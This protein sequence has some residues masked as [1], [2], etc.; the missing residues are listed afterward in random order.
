MR[1]SSIRFQQILVTLPSADPD[2]QLAIRKRNPKGNLNFTHTRARTSTGI[3]CCSK[4]HS[5]TCY[6]QKALS[7]GFQQFTPKQTTSGSSTMIQYKS[8]SPAGRSRSSRREHG[9]AP[10]ELAGRAEQRGSIASLGSP[11]QQV[12]HLGRLAVVLAPCAPPRLL[13]LLPQLP[14]RRHPGVAR[15]QRAPERR[16]LRPP[17]LPVA[18]AA[19]HGSC[20]RRCCATV[21]ASK[22]LSALLLLSP[23]TNIKS[24]R[25]YL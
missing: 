18:A 14:P 12:H 2:F 7:Y 8:G 1:F 9:G 19:A 6:L 16:E 17:A 20:R 22:H 21:V 10:R 24:R 13:L 5:G 3:L 23:A 15:H 11:E 25:F 4:H